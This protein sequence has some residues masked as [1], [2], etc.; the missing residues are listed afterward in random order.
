MQRCFFLARNAPGVHRQI[1]TAA[2]SPTKG[3]AK[4]VGAL[5]CEQTRLSQK[6]QPMPVTV[7]R[8]NR[9]ISEVLL[10]PLF[11]NQ[12]HALLL[13]CIRV[14]L[15]QEQLTKTMVKDCH[16]TLTSIK[17][18]FGRVCFILISFHQVIYLALD[19]RKVCSSQRGGRCENLVLAMM[20]TCHSDRI[21]QSVSWTRFTSLF[22][23]PVS[24]TR[25]QTNLDLFIPFQ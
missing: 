8:L 14:L 21:A 6:D 11:L 4:E 7:L 16:V 10:K 3:P 5:L 17:H 18:R 22:Q 24:Y 12:K 15:K 25:G 1:H 23:E 2:N 20:A 19:A 9:S 13:I